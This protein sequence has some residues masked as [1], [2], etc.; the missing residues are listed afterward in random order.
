VFSICVVSFKIF[1]RKCGKRVFILAVFGNGLDWM[2]WTGTITNLINMRK[3]KSKNILYI[4]VKF[5]VL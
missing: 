3:K 4:K 2:K 1:I 5:F